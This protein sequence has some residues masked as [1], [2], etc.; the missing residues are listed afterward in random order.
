MLMLLNQIKTTTF[1]FVI[2]SV[3]VT[4][5]FYLNLIRIT[6][7]FVLVGWLLKERDFYKNDMF[8]KISSV[9]MYYDRVS[10]AIK[11]N[12]TLEVFHSHHKS[13]LYLASGLGLYP[14]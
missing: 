2:D 10:A 12:I 5:C 1:T 14:R 13:I 11:T 6:E 3:M 7:S 4:C 9:C 8:Q